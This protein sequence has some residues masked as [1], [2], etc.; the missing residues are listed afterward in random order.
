MLDRISSGDA[1]P[2]LV[3]FILVSM[4]S[5]E[6]FSILVHFVFGLLPFNWRFLNRLRILWRKYDESC[7]GVVDLE[8]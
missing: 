8:G 7:W 5:E 6:L 2:S 3:A 1:F 4:S